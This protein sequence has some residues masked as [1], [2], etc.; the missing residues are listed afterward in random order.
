MNGSETGIN[1]DATS[2]AG[3]DAVTRKLPYLSGTRPP[4]TFV[5]AQGGVDFHC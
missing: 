1:A 2:A 4:A 3:D 5:E